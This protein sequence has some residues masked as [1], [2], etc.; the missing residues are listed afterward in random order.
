MSDGYAKLG[1]MTTLDGGSIGA[2]N[3][4]SLGN[5]SNLVGRGEVNARVAAELGS[6]IEAAGPLELGDAGSS[7][8]FVSA[9]ELRT[10]RHVVSLHSFAQA[11]LGNL[12]AVGDGANPGRIDA[13]NGAIVDFGHSLIGFGTV[14]S[15]NSLAKRTIINGVAG[16][17]S[18][19]QPLT[20]SGYVK[21]VGTFNNVAF[22]GTFDPGLSPS[23][24]TVGTISLSSTSTL[25]MEI[26]GPSPG[27]GYDQI[28]ASGT[29]VLNGALRISLIN[30]F[31][32]AIG[33][34][35]NLFDW[36]V[37]QGS[38]SVLQL[39]ALTGGLSWDASQLYSTGVLTVLGSALAADFDGDGIVGAD[40][41]ANWKTGFGRTVATRGQGDADGDRDVD[42]SDFLIWQR[43]VGS[44]LPVAATQA[45]VPEPTA[46]W[47]LTL[48]AIA[49]RRRPGGDR[50]KRVRCRA[51]VA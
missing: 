11:T 19:T 4:V 10:R 27:S 36:N 49:I 22:T 2:I 6:I 42:G 38:F 46:Q 26:G 17:L 32:P 28:Q 40:D 3:G 45:A 12:T 39:P 13:A 9:G 16:G 29:L 51:H 5:G 21:G 20:F 30:G 33:S 35:F 48:G 50:V 37:V 8:G 41:L 23:I 44:G 25:I 31:E 1:V 15:T 34:S 18:A 7:A 14:S 24:L 47:L 43:Q